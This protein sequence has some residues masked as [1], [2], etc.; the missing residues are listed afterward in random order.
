MTGR[1]FSLD[2]LRNEIVAELVMLR[3]DTGERSQEEQFI[4]D[5][6]TFAKTWGTPDSAFIRRPPQMQ[7]IQF[8]I[9]GQPVDPSMMSGGEPWNTTQQQM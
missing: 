1:Q 5:V 3:H 7:M 6:I 2:D 4:K 9:N 8:T